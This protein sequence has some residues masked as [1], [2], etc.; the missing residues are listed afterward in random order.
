MARLSLC[1]LFNLFVAGLG[2]DLGGVHP[3]QGE[4]GDNCEWCEC[5][6]FSSYLH[7]RS[8]HSCQGNVTHSIVDPDPQ[9]FETF[10]RIRIRNSSLW[11]RIRIR[12]WT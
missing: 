5:S 6:A 4:G 8:R 3:R 1:C 12:N 10:C 2:G 9:G 11:I 7:L